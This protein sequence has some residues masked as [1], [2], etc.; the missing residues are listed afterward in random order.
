MT[1]QAFVTI[2][3]SADFERVLST[4]AKVQT[5][6]FALHHIAPHS[7]PLHGREDRGI[8]LRGTAGDSLAKLSTAPLTPVPASVDDLFAMI[9]TEPFEPVLC[10]P[11]KSLWRLGMVIPKKHAKRA[12]TRVLIKRQVRALMHENLGSSRTTLLRLWPEGDWVIRLRS[13]FDQVAF[14]SASS[15]ALKQTVRQELF[16]LFGQFAQ[17]TSADRAKS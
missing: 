17:R 3:A 10:L 7:S 9:V 1:G 16:A 5:P 13:S 4:R 14:V 15:E 11:K 2:T 6:H 8:G 12:A